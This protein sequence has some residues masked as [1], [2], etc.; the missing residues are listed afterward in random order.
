MNQGIKNKSI[1]KQDKTVPKK[2]E[3]PWVGLQVRRH[4][5]GFLPC[6]IEQSFVGSSLTL[7]SSFL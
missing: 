5:R 6:G 7:G 1:L 4:L 2:E 3:L